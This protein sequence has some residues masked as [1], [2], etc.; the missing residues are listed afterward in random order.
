MQGPSSANDKPL[1]QPAQPDSSVQRYQT[2]PDGWQAHAAG[3]QGAM[4]LPCRAHTAPTT[5]WMTVNHPAPQRGA[6]SAHQQWSTPQGSG[7]RGRRVFVFLPPPGLAADGNA[8]VAAPAGSQVSTRPVQQ[9]RHPLPAIRRGAAEDAQ[10]GYSMGGADPYQLAA[11]VLRTGAPQRPQRPAS[12]PA[13]A[14]RRRK[15][16]S[17]L[18]GSRPPNVSCTFDPTPR[19][20]KALTQSTLQQAVSRH[21]VSKAARQQQQKEN[22]PADDAASEFGSMPCVSQRGLQAGGEPSCIIGFGQLH[23]PLPAPGAA[24]LTQQPRNQPCTSRLPPRQPSMLPAADAKPCSRWQAPAA[25]GAF[26]RPALLQA[27]GSRAART[28]AG[29]ASPWV[30]ADDTPEEPRAKL[31]RRQQLQRLLVVKPDPFAKASRSGERWAWL[32]QPLDSQGRAGSDPEHDPTTIL[33]PASAWGTDLKGADAQ[34]WRIKQEGCAHMVLFFQEGG[35]ALRGG[36]QHCS[37]TCS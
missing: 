5:A 37:F 4:Q 24:T 9:T 30:P 20:Q 7:Q 17:V 29:P 33:I 27:D 21:W 19:P 3:A 35:Q 10:G 32:Q 1:L 31:E 11:P 18:A 12:A 26:G 2:Q 28:V 14:A 16:N 6:A 25:V 23:S 34:Y 13:D 15:A 22:Y 36:R 8:G